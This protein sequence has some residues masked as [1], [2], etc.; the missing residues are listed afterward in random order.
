MKDGWQVCIWSSLLNRPYIYLSGPR[1][2]VLSFAV[3][4]F[5]VAYS[6]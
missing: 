1:C 6:L 3:R 2:G 5:L 4:I